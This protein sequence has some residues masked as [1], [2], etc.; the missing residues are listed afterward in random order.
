M[1]IHVTTST[2]QTLSNKSF[3]GAT[4]FDGDVT[5]FGNLSCNGTQTFQNTIFSTTSAVS[6]VHVGSGPALWVGNNGLGDIASFY[7]MDQNIEVLHVGGNNGSFPNVGVKTSTPNVDFTVRGS[8]SASSIIYDATGNSNNWNNAYSSF[9]AQSAKNDSVY[10]TVNTNSA[11]AF[12]RSTIGITIDG[13]GSAITTGSKG[14]ISVPY[15]CTINNNTIIADQT[16]SIVIDVKKS[17]YAGFPT[18][19]SICA[20]AKPT[21]T[22]AQK[23]TDSTLAGWTTTVTAGDVIEFVVDSASTITKATLTLGVTKT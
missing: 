12:T 2:T 22:S 21:L 11:T 18:T 16:G 20:A 1:P 19:T 23:S 6:V 4:R 10:S 8:I 15:S 17:T 7:D 13:G 5:I 9:N 14:Y 3:S